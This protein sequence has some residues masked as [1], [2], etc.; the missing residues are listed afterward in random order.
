MTSTSKAEMWRVSTATVAFEK[1][2]CGGVALFQ[3][4]AVNVI[5]L[6]LDDRNS[7]SLLMHL[8]RFEQEIA[9][10]SSRSNW[11]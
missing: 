9:G 2:R 8:G 7:W 5:P 11:I 6:V 4:R 1:F 10:N 3:G